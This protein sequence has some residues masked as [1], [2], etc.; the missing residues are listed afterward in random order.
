MGRPQVANPR[1]VKSV[2]VPV[3]LQGIDLTWIINE[4]EIAYCKIETGNTD[5]A[6]LIKELG[7]L[8]VSQIRFCV[9]DNRRK[10]S[11]FSFSATC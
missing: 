8:L 9:A 10:N 7:H 1:K 5:T 2:R 3:E 11:M 4:M 6:K